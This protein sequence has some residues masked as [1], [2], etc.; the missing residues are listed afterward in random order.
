MKFWS[1]IG[2]L[3]HKVWLM[4][5]RRPLGTAFEIFFP[6][7]LC[8]LLIYVRDEVE[9]EVQDRSYGISFPVLSLF[10]GISLPTTLKSQEICA[11]EELVGFI[12]V[13]P[14]TSEVRTFLD[15]L[16]VYY[17]Y[18]LETTVTDYYNWDY[19]ASDP[20]NFRDLIILIDQL[21]PDADLVDALEDLGININN[22][23]QLE[24]VIA[25]L[26]STIFGI[27][28]QQFEDFYAFLTEFEIDDAV[29]SL[30]NLTITFNVSDPDT[31]GEI[32]EFVCIS[33]CIFFSP[34]VLF[35]SLPGY[36]Y[37]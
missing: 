17:N 29:D 12:G 4:K 33:N 31:I 5:K 6:V 20:D 22:D 8:S 11:G 30:D 18:V 2:L 23:N 15:E 7:L 36:L 3:L 10:S 16:E 37:S 19:F 13:A 26:N 28:Q 1:Q 25:I 24:F 34:F 35:Y 32:N 21:I 9:V 27:S 14:N